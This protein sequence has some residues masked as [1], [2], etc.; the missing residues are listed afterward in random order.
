M[1]VLLGEH[2]F[3]IAQQFL[4]LYFIVPTI[5]AFRQEVFLQITK[6]VVFLPGVFVLFVL[7]FF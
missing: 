7:E 6:V 5:S 2:F 1:H 3:G 4:F